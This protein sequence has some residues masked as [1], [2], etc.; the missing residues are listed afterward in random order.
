M[1]LNKGT[2]RRTIVYF[3]IIT[4]MMLLTSIFLTT[5]LKSGLA[6]VNWRNAPGNVTI[7]EMTTHWAHY[8]IRPEDESLGYTIASDANGNPTVKGMPTQLFV[9]GVGEDFEIPEHWAFKA[10]DAMR[11]SGYI[12]T[13]L[14][15]LCFIGILVNVVRGIKNELYFTRMQVLLLRWSALFCFISTIA[16]ELCSKF[17][18]LAIG[19]MYGKSSSIK[20][21]AAY[22]IEIQ[23]IIIPFLL[24]MFAEIINIAMQLNKEESMT[25]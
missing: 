8:S 5:E 15:M 7:G 23:Q 14:L 22:Q 25:I 12:F 10:S 4:L 2:Q 19:Q 24:L 9:Y 3:S 16:T 6:R 20:L 13:I 11:I 18:M 1:K 17:N 21:A